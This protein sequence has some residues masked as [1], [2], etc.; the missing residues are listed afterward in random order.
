MSRTIAIFGGSFNP[1][2]AH[3]RAIAE[4]LSS[5]FDEVVVVPCGPRPDKPVTNDVPPIY[6][7]AMADM[8]FRDIPR[9]RVALFDLEA[10]TFTR[11]V[12]LDGSC[13][14]GPATWKR[15]S[16]T[17]VARIEKGGFRP[18]WLEEVD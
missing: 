8:T 15:S 7:A 4:R 10:S 13:A 6:R 5:H 2:G 1:S 11:T 18:F 14:H 16:R 9:V 3:H 12:D 17:G